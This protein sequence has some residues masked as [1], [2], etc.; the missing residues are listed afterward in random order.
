MFRV[1]K[2]TYGNGG[3]C[4]VVQ[5]QLLRSG[6][7]IDQKEWITAQAFTGLLAEEDALKY[8]MNQ[9]KEIHNWK[10][11][12]TEIIYPSFLQTEK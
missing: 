5:K 12:S 8:A 1:V 10:I 9:E 6:N 2:H 11:V 3:V 4:Y 7:N